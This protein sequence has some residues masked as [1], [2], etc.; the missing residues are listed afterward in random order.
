[1]YRPKIKPIDSTLELASSL[2]SLN[3]QAL[4]EIG[5]SVAIDDFGTGYSSLAYL[6]NLP[7]DYLKIDRVFVKDIVSER[8]DTALN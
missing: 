8:S 5:V 7:I 4:L 3:E 6:K 2:S 1:M